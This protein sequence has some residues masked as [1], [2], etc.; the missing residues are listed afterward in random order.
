MAMVG[1]FFLTV[2]LLAFAAVPVGLVLLAGHFVLEQDRRLDDFR[3]TTAIV[4][5]STV[6]GRTGARGA[7]VYRPRVIYTFDV[8]K[9]HYTGSHVL[10]IDYSGR[11]QWAISTAGLFHA[12]QRC[13]VWYDPA[14]PQQAYLI[15]SASFWPYGGFLVALPLALLFSV[16]LTTTAINI[17]TERRSP[18]GADAEGWLTLRPSHEVRGGWGGTLLTTAIWYGA[19]VFVVVDYA[20]HAHAAPPTLAVVGLVAYALLGIAPVAVMFVRQRTAGRLQTPVVRIRPAT[21]FPGDTVEVETSIDFLRPINRTVTLGWTCVRTVPRG[22]YRRSEVL[23]EFIQ[24]VPALESGR[25]E[26]ARACVPL[27]LPADLPATLGG[28]ESFGWRIELHLRFD[29]GGGYAGSY[30][31]KVSKR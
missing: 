12:G 19:E 28:R 22:R 1:R 31:F 3:Q 15:R 23:R 21:V 27:L 9:A 18:A 17:W 7:G 25:V 26:T 24:P 16:T 14:D 5:S 6:E 10:P 30:P 8:G 2:V 13:P 20:R 29:G 11:P 4:Q